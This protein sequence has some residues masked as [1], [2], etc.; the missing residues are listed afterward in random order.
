MLPAGV[1]RADWFAM[2]RHIGYEACVREAIMV[3]TTL[4]IDDDVGRFFLNF[5]SWKRWIIFC[6]IEVS[7]IEFHQ[8]WIIFW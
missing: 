8:F 7:N 2:L 3:V 5:T 6:F 4:G 1:M